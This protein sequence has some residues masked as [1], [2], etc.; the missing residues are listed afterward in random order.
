MNVGPNEH[1]STIGIMQELS[2]LWVV[3]TVL[4][5]LVF[6]GLLYFKI[7]STVGIRMKM[8]DVWRMIA[9]FY[10]LTQP[11]REATWGYF[12]SFSESISIQSTQIPLGNGNK[13]PKSGVCQCAKKQFDTCQCSQS[14][15]VVACLF[16]THD[17]KGLATLNMNARMP[18]LG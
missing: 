17:R 1:S 11:R 2:S 6:V 5:L 9:R 16:F 7:Y 12:N 3:I 8:L 4:F 14:E 18:H 15:E 13:A 10:F